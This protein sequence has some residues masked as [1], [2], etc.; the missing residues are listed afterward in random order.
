MPLTMRI[1]W[2]KLT[3]HEKKLMF[4]FQ[5]KA[6]LERKHYECIRVNGEMLCE[7]CKKPYWKHEADQNFPQSLVVDCEGRKLHL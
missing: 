7:W 1:N 3:E 6:Q 2:D 5:A 4:W